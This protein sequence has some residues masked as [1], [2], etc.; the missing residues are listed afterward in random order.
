VGP[1]GNVMG[2]LIEKAGS[3]KYFAQLADQAAADWKFVPA[4]KPKRV[5]LVL[6][7]FTRNGVS[8]QAMAQ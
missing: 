8:A 2:T 5:W 3:S 1:D 4:A 6:F 7:V